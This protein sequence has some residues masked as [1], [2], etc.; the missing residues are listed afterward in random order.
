[1]F[2]SDSINCRIL[3]RQHAARGARKP[4][5]GAVHGIGT[6]GVT[7]ARCS[8]RSLHGPLGAA[9]LSSTLV[10]RKRPAL[11]VSE[12]GFLKLGQAAVAASVKG[13]R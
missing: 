11:A 7:L 9:L 10:R 4:V 2:G 1:M 8:R 12:F 3:L 6:L 13:E 5:G